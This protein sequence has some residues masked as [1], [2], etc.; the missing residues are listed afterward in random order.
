MCFKTNVTLTLPLK[1]LK[2]EHACSVFLSLVCGETTVHR[3]ALGIPGDCGLGAAHVW[4]TA[5]GRLQ[6]PGVGIRLTRGG[7]PDLLQI[8]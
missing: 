1:C 5:E 8:M 7:I 2:V 6:A 4:R 3:H